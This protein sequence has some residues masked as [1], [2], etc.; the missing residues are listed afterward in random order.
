MCEQ[1]V[2]DSPGQA[3]CQ[4]SA[5]ERLVHTKGS[6]ETPLS[7]PARIPGTQN[8]EIQG[9]GCDV[10]PLRFVAVCHAAKKTGAE[11]GDCHIRCVLV[12]FRRV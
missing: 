4:L 11:F 8:C 12:T 7:S 10:K 1:A 2:L 9:S 5:T 6:Q 3:S